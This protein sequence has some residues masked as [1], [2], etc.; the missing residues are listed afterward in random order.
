MSQEILMYSLTFVEIRLK[1]ES[2][3][4]VYLNDLKI[5]KFKIYNLDLLL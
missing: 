2:L 5:I 4:L 1:N 3:M